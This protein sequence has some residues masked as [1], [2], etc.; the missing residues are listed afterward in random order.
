MSETDCESSISR[1]TISDAAVPF[2][3]RG[4][5]LFPGQVITSDPG[6]EDSE[7]VLVVDKMNIPIGKVQ[8]FKG[9]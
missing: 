5:R 6:I 3:A 2:I 8:I 1:V 7:Q 9:V 4:G